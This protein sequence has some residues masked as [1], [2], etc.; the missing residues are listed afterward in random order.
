LSGACG[1]DRPG[2][3]LTDVGFNTIVVLCPDLQSLD[4]SY[5][6]LATADSVENILRNCKQLCELHVPRVQIRNEDLAGLVG[7]PD[8][9][10]LIRFGGPGFTGP[11][12]PPS[13]KLLLRLVGVLYSCMDIR[14]WWKYSIYRNRSEMKQR[15][16]KHCW[17][18]PTKISMIQ[19]H[20]M[21]GNGSIEIE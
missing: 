16:R 17:K 7:L 6:G 11:S 2:S 13:R 1:D 15:V 14:A 21:N 8:T 3:Y 19:T 20:T 18:N 4:L 9:L 5:H 12:L 10:L